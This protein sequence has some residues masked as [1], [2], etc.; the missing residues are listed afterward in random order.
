MNEE[1]NCFIN[2]LEKDFKKRISK[3]HS[4]YRIYSIRDRV[5]N[6][7]YAKSC[8]DAVAIVDYAK[9]HGYPKATWGATYPAGRAYVALGK[10]SFKDSK[11]SQESDA[12]DSSILAEAQSKK[13]H[14]EVEKKTA[15]DIIRLIDDMC[16]NENDDVIWHSGAYVR[17]K[18]IAKKIKEKYKQ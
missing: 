3:A 8:I 12:A 1:S 14:D 11:Q 10:G 4:I 6:A 13:M 9:A 16:A 2:C 7:I 5:S 17:N 15:E 18:A